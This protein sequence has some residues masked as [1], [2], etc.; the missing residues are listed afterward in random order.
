MSSCR[1]KS[2]MQSWAEREIEIACQRERAESGSKEGEFDY[3]CACYESALKA[4][5]SL[6]EDGHSGFSIGVTK[7]ILSR[8]IEGKPIS[9]IEDTEDV[10]NDISDISGLDGEMANYQCKRMSSLFKYVY[11]D[12]TVKYRD[13][14]RYY[15]VTLD[16]PNCSYHNGL[17]DKVMD[18]LYPIRMPYIPCDRSSKVVC[19]EFLTDRKN[20]DFDTVGILYFIDPNGIRWELNRYFKEAEDDFVEI[21]EE[22]YEERRVMYQELLK[23][24]YDNEPK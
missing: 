24:E 2:N 18:E 8:L 14:D 23:K 15:G 13:V 16:N 6:L 1:E 11:P 3:G 7:H 12:G 5:N 21:G 20:G 17:I 19:E 4:Y 10:W 22:E 9:P